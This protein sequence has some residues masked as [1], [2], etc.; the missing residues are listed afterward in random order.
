[1]TR[2]FVISI[3][4]WSL[5]S[6]FRC[7]FSHD[8][9]IFRLAHIELRAGVEV[10]YTNRILLQFRQ[11]AFL[12]VPL[13]DTF[14]KSHVVL[15]S[16]VGAPH[17]CSLLKWILFPLEIYAGVLWIDIMAVRLTYIYDNPPALLQEGASVRH[18]MLLL[19]EHRR[20]VA[21]V[22]DLECPYV[23]D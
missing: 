17:L 3:L 5:F 2:N 18:Q 23:S 12:L 19:F 20:E 11:F 9:L 14:S 7:D 22:L 8:V 6:F 10:P 15:S 21:P 13:S 1:M 4:F 16:I